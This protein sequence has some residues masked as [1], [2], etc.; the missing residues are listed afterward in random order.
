MLELIGM[1]VADL[2][3]VA[4]F[5]EERAAYEANQPRF[6]GAMVSRIVKKVCADKT[7][8]KDMKSQEMAWSKYY[9]DS[10][11]A[12]KAQAQ[13]LKRQRVALVTDEAKLC[14]DFKARVSETAR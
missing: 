13:R 7:F 9:E 14:R 5:A 8:F 4:K 2:K 12:T 10:K 1:D 3:W 11:S 6:T